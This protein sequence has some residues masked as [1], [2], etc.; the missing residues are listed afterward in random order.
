MGK[1]SETLIWGSALEQGGRSAQILGFFKIRDIQ[2]FSFGE[3]YQR[4]R[5][6]KTS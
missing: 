5:K 1:S 3:C 4:L 6:T 2:L